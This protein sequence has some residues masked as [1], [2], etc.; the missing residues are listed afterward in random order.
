MK[1]FLMLVAVGVAF[2]LVGCVEEPAV[3]IDQGQTISTEIGEEFVVALD[4]NPTTG[5]NWEESYDET[6][7]KLVEKT[8]ELGESDKKGLIG[9]GG[10][11]NFRFK[12]IGKGTTEITLVYKRL[13]EQEI[14]AQAV[15]KVDI[16]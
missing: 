1:K 6:A 5:Y 12:A 8:F 7:L 13:W 3:Y 14:A 10:I 11:E 16:K 15:F 4:A 2:M 9:A